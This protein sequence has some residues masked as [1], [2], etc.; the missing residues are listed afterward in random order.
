MSNFPSSYAVLS[1]NTVSDDSVIGTL[2]TLKRE[3]AE[4]TRKVEE[5][6][7]VM[8][9]VEQVTSEYLP[10]A[11]ASSS[12]FF[13]LDELHLLNHFYQFSLR[14]FLDIFDF[15]LL[16][17]PSLTGVTDPRL[18]L[19]ILIHDL[20]LN[21][22]KRTSRTLLHSDHL[23]LAVLLAQVKLRGSDADFDER[24][25]AFL[26]EGGDSNNLKSGSHVASS[27]ILNE[28]QSCRLEAF[29]RLPCFKYV[30]QSI[31]DHGNEWSMM[32]DSASPEL[33]I[34]AGI[35]KEGASSTLLISN[36][37]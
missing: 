35:W 33:C 26:L 2:E 8:A 10:L 12:I 34:P 9:E 11:Q 37:I 28:D 27:S 36:A 19:D 17:N 29:G 4:V 22:F 1:L 16:H 30:Q 20:F 23:V 32:I 6:D 7:V 14:F 31:V 18:R 5:T 3:A 25:Y 15:I 13:V 24:E 21:V